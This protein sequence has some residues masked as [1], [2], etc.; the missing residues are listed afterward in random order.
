M[1]ARDRANQTSSYTCPTTPPS[2]F[3]KTLPE[4][5]SSTFDNSHTSKLQYSPTKPAR[6]SLLSY[7]ALKQTVLDCLSSLQVRQRLINML[8]M[9]IP[10]PAYAVTPPARPMRFDSSV[11]MT[12]DTSLVLPE[13][14]VVTVEGLRHCDLALN[15]K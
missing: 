2:G 14:G 11:S 7:H 6:S 8:Q 13:E 1:S 10:S 9:A 3:R 5:K 12:S 15:S 4:L